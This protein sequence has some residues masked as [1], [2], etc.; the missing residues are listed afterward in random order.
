MK[1]CGTL[2]AGV[3]GLCV[4][5]AALAQLPAPNASGVT[6]GHTHLTVP[7][8]ARHA[9]IWKALGA[10]QQSESRFVMPGMYI[11]LT[12]REPGAPSAETS[13]NHLGF[14]V[15]DYAEY[16]AKLEAVNASFFFDNAEDGQILADLPD[17][18]RIE[19]LVDDEQ[20]APIAFHHYHLAAADPAALQAWY[21]EAFG[22]EAGERRGLPSAIVPGGRVDFLPV[23]GDAP[24][25]SRGNAID[26]IGFEVSDM[27]AFAKRMEELGIEFDMPPT[28]VSAIGLT[29]AFITDPSGTYVEIT[30]G[31]R[32]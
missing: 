24:L 5:S 2:V 14:T 3:A 11:L 13:A 16:K 4:A 18:V 23:R 6:T 17:G 25:P 20:E 10:E 19:I 9:E 22:A 30:Q 12:E 27:A 26:H 1:R 32:E 28:E 21:L 7:S 29:I 8:I 15:R 31:L